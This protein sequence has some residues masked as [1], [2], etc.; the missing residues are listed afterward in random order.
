MEENEGGWGGGMMIVLINV[1]ESND[2]EMQG[3]IGK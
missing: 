2:R 1:R 3:C